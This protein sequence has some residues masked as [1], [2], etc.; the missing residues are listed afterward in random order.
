MLDGANLGHLWVFRDVT[1]QAEI[2]RGLEERARILSELATLKTEFVAVVSHEL[3]TPL[4]SINTFANMLEEEGALAPDERADA[5]TAIRRNADR[6]LSLV[7]DLILLAKLDSGELK[8]ELAP[9]DVPALV[10]RAIDTADSAH[11]GL[12]VELGDGPPFTGDP[13][14]LAQLVDTA[15]GVV[16]SGSAPGAQVVVT[17]GSRPEGW[18]IAVTTSAA[19]AATAE[20]LLSTR[21]PHP[22]A[23][24]ERRTGALAVMLARAIA[25]RHGGDFSMAMRSPGAALTIDLPN[26]P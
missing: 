18:H 5:M 2:R 1:A 26:T 23:A 8:L 25:T 3:R 24:N 15:V 13:R 16:V 14:L 12:D 21:L 19:D 9:V 20:R 4:T 10:R 11:V 17:T 6:M 7:A 22:D